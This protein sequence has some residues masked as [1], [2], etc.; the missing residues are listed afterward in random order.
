VG[1]SC[2]NSCAWRSRPGSGAASLAAGRLEARPTTGGLRH[3]GGSRAA[4]WAEAQILY[5][6]QAGY[7]SLV[8]WK[9]VPL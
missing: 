1:G 6:S 8:S 7:V 9:S 3:Q 2:L 4:F 5:M